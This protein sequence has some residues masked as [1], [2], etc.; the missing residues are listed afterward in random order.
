MPRAFSACKTKVYNR[1]IPPEEFLNELVDWCRQAPDEIF[2]KN[3]RTDIYSQVFSELGP[4]KD[5]LHRKAAMLEV[6]RVLGGFESSWDWGAGVH[7]NKPAP[8]TPCT[9][10]AGIFQCS[11]DS[12]NFDASLKQ[13]LQSAAGKTDCD[14]FRSTTKSNHRF[15]IE[16]CARLLRFTI[17]HNGPVKRKEINPWLK[18]EAV[19]EFRRFLSDAS[20]ASFVSTGEN[21]VRTSSLSL[22]KDP[23]VVVLAAG[24][25]GSAPGAVHAG[26]QES[27]QAITI[28]DQIAK[29]LREK[30][31][32]VVVVPHE[33]DFKASIKWI[34]ERYA[35]GQAW[36]IEIHR[37]SA[38]GLDFKDA[39]SR[40]GVY[41]GDSEGS[42]AIGTFLRDAFKTHGANEKTWARP[43]TSAN[44]GRLAW[45]A[46]T[47]P[48]AHLLELAFMQGKNDQ[49]HLMWLANVATAAIFEAFTGKS[50]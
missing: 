12:M 37:D 38:T 28:T 8:N 2:T 42:K 21:I 18:K 19:A 10:E 15:A 29:V 31:V 24:H 33:Y 14:T 25:G 35:F 22:L 30:G 44:G 40:F 4:W 26:H 27:K 6:L 41:Y 50:F 43:H 46:D 32:E 5:L 34:N 16:Y 20:T 23:N 39:S 7:E 45:I 1:G 13:L 11:G 17:N 36:V 9:E 47:K 48:V 3:D 49:E